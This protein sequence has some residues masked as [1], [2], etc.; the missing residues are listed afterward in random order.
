LKSGERSTSCR[1]ARVSEVMRVGSRNNAPE[2]F[3]ITPY[4]SYKSQFMLQ[5]R[6]VQDLDPAT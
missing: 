1:Q 5:K 2:E 3:N 6:D 4:E